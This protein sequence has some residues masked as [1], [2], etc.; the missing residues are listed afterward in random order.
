MKKKRVL[1]A[2]NVSH[3]VDLITNSSSELFVL[4]GKTL[5]NVK[6]MLDSVYPNWRSEYEEPVN[7]KDLTYDQLDNYFSYATGS[8][9]WPAESKSNY[10]VP[11]GFTFDE[12]YEESDEKAWNNRKQ[13]KVRNNVKNPKHEYDTSFVT[14]EN[15]EEIR[16]KMFPDGDAYF[17]YSLDENPNWEMQE[18]LMGIGERY[19]LG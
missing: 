4:K 12:V 9:M 6:E 8:Y 18:E 15:F 2:I 11:S 13:Y 10:K 14:E 3:T 17:L 7:V 5:D 19:H 16:K 1:F